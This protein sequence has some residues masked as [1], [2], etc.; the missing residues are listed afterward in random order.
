[1]SKDDIDIRFDGRQLQDIVNELRDMNKNLNS[2]SK[3]LDHISS[4]QKKDNSFSNNNT[5]QSKVVDAL[6]KIADIIK[7]KKD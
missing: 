4:E 2:I 3:T 7:N 5:I 1:M 6:E